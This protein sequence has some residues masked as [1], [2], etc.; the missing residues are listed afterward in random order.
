MA[1][2]SSWRK[3]VTLFSTPRSAAVKETTQ[4]PRSAPRIVIKVVMV[5]GRVGNSYMLSEIDTAQSVHR[6]GRLTKTISR[7]SHRRSFT[8]RPCASVYWFDCYKRKEEKLGGRVINVRGSH[9]EELIDR[10]PVE[11]SHRKPRKKCI[12]RWKGEEGSAP[13][14]LFLRYA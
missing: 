6:T 11:W 5:R 12:R 9:V 14:P 10:G 3:D 8:E 2:H 13:T 4:L 7:K 1:D